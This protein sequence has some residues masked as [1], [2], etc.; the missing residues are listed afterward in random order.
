MN[1]LYYGDTLDLLREGA[2]GGR[3]AIGCTEDFPPGSFEKTFTGMGR[4]MARY[5]GYEW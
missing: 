2:P 1:R 3:L 5:G 4:A